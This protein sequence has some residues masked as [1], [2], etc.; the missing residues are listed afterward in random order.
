[1]Q[2]KQVAVEV[3]M[4]LAAQ[5]LVDRWLRS[6]GRGPFMRAVSQEVQERW[7]NST[8][9]EA[10]R[11]TFRRMANAIRLGRGPWRVRLR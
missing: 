6:P 7:D 4:M 8:D 9:K 5:Q 1:M 10:Q 3:A 11:R 2:K